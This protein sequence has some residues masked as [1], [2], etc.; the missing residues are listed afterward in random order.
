M[1]EVG[2]VLATG[3]E[4]LRAME[5]AGLDVDAAAGQVRFLL[6]VGRDLFMEV[7]KLR[8]ARRLWARW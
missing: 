6:P 1:Q 8:A 5:R 7:A 3:V 2:F 4:Y